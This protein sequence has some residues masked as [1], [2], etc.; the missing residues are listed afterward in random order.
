MQ[1]KPGRSIALSDHP[2]FYYAP[3]WSPDGR[4][5]AYLDKHLALWYVDA[6]SGAPV[7][8]DTDQFGGGYRIRKLRHPVWSPDSRS[9]A[10]TK[11]RSNHLR[12]LFLYSLET[13]KTQQITDGMSDVRYPCFDRGGK[14]LYFTSSTD[15]GPSG[16]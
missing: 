2:S 6:A 10:Y 9:I 4:K 3:T 13:A 16:R 14:Y 12:A 8:V 1:I 15:L 11:E 5:V 7:K